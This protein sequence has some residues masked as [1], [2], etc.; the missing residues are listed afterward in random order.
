MRPDSAGAGLHRGG[1]GAVYEIEALTAADVFLLG[2]RGVFAPFGVAG[3]TP[4]ALNRFVWQSDEGEK[5]PPLASKV[6]D[7]RI[8]DGQGNARPTLT[9]A[10]VLLGRINAERPIGGKLARLGVDA[11]RT[12]IATHVAEPLGLDV[13]AAAEAVVCIANSKMAGAIRLV[14]IERGHDPAKFAAVPF[15]GGG[16]LHVG[17]LIKEVGL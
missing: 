8:R 1:L 16:A 2:E 7:V 4:A 5:S 15:G 17:A 12:A 6:T 14:S 10:N 13:M 3:G 9:D 11:A